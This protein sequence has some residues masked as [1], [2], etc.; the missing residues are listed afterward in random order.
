MM[1][2]VILK[3]IIY[4]YKITD[5]PTSDYYRLHKNLSLRKYEEK[6]YGKVRY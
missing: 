3:I 6:N 4:K 2:F 5:K 1:Q